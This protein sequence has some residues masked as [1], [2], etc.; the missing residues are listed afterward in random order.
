MRSNLKQAIVGPG[1]SSIEFHERAKLYNNSQS[2]RIAYFKFTGANCFWE[3]HIH[4]FFPFMSF[5]FISY[6]EKLLLSFLMGFVGLALK[7]W[8]AVS[9]H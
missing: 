9:N 8:L 5:G 7:L 2:N 3:Q 4:F 1:W 6:A